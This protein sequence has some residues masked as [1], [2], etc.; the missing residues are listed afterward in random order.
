MLPTVAIVGRPNCGKSTIF[1]RIIGQRLSIVEDVPGVTRDR[2]YAQA[3][4]LGHKFNLI[5]T[6]GIEID[7]TPFLTEITE[8]V[9]IAIREADVILLVCDV[10]DGKT[11]SDQYV[12]ELLYKSQKPVICVVNKVD[13]ISFKEAAYEF[14]AL[15]FEDVISVSSTHGIGFGDLLDKLIEKL[16]HKVFKKYAEDTIKLC[17]IGRPNVGKSSL[18]N[19]LLGENRVIV[20]DTP[21]TTRDAID[22]EFTKD[23]KAYV[24]IDTAGMRKKGKVYETTEKYSVLRAMSAIERSEICIVL[25]NAEEGIIEYDKR[26]AGFAHNNN[27][28]VILCVN[29][30]DK[31]KKDDK[32]MN[33]WI[34]KIRQE[35]IFLAYAPIV[36]ISAKENKR[37]HTLFAAINQ[38]FENYSRRI[39]TYV[40]NDTILDAVSLN[41]A[42]T[43]NGGKLKVYYITQVGIKPPTFVIFV[44]N[45]NY[46]HFSYERFID[47]K[48]RENFEF[49]GTPIKIIARIRD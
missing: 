45:P 1:N 24:V 41:P 37:I 49:T 20:S 14:Y 28:A 35:F 16:P 10:R 31:I 2:I 15:G 21:G 48:L 23:G 27:K 12:A 4:W 44:N 34:T 19:V 7:N 29:K 5:D 25:L 42:P 8:Q 40:L 6:G 11:P 17:L 26:I 18:T 47:N 39:V 30:W 33:E 43:H 3:E 13:D 38:A 36:F 22:T 32:T 46:L 9:E